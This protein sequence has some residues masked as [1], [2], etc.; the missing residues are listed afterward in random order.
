MNLW[1]AG[2]LLGGSVVLIVAI[3]LLSILYQARRILNLARTAATVV[4]EIDRNTQ[5]IWN[6]TATKSV[7]DDV[8]R[9]AS[10]ISG[11][12]QTVSAVVNKNIKESENVC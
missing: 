7:A 9:H 11:N 10:D 12:A 8:L 6:L 1:S 5:T 4:A 2:F 3:L